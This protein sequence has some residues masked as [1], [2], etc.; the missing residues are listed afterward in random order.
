ML[1][2]FMHKISSLF[3]FLFVDAAAAVFAPEDTA[4]KRNTYTKTYFDAGFFSLLFRSKV[5]TVVLRF[6]WNEA[7]KTH[8]HT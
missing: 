4:T 5:L 7:K 1:F 2:I 8:S 3:T 6:F